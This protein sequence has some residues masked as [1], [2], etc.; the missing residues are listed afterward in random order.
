MTWKGEHPTVFEWFDKTYEKGKKLGNKA[1]MEIEE[2]LERLAGL[3]KWFVDIAS[4]P[5]QMAAAMG[6]T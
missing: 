3:P 4:A 6:P 5:A 1:M 2:R